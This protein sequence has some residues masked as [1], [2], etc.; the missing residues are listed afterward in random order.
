MHI[1]KINATMTPN[2]IRVHSVISEKNKLE[3]N[4]LYKSPKKC[5]FLGFTTDQRSFMEI[6]EDI[7][8]YNTLYIHNT[9]YLTI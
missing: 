9:T 2:R 4:R 7:I 8:T 6:N 1:Y 5:Y 3:E